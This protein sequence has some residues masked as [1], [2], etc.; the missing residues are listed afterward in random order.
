MNITLNLGVTMATLFF[1]SACGAMPTQFVQK[2]SFYAKLKI[3]QD[4]GSTVTLTTSNASLR[5]PCT[6]SQSLFQIHAHNSDT[7]LAGRIGFR[8]IDQGPKKLGAGTSVSGDK[9]GAINLIL[10]TANIKP[11][12]LNGYWNTVNG[13][14]LETTITGNCLFP[15]KATA[16][17]HFKLRIEYASLTG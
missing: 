14:I 6:K 3:Q 7:T 16:G 2:Y 13:D 4:L 12:G 1:V 9:G 15:G 5:I 17:E 10:D 8:I 11:A